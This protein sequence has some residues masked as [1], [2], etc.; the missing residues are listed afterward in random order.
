MRLVNRAFFS[1]E[2][3]SSTTTNHGVR[4]GLALP[5]EEAEPAETP[6]FEVLDGELREALDELEL[7]ELTEDCDSL[8]VLE[9]EIK[10]EDV[11]S[12]LPKVTTMQIALD[13]GACEH[14]ASKEDLAGFKIH[15]NAASRRGD[16]YIAANGDKVPNQG[17][18]KVG[19]K[20]PNTNKEFDSLFQLAPV[21]RP[22]YSVGRICDTGCEVGFNA[23]RAVVTR[24]GREIAIFERHHGLYLAK[25]EVKGE[26][27][28]ASTFVGQDGKN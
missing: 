22:L 4:G 13:S 27:D 24:G 1:D 20:D 3:K 17:E 6:T 8:N 11:L 25:V 21:S 9:H 26:A 2:P 7:I 5:A 28:P 16:C 15:E 14:V 12:L 10:S 19:L 18:C 23:K